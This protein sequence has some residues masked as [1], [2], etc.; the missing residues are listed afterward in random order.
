MPSAL[1][2]GE[3]HERGLDLLKPDPA[4]LLG[5]SRRFGKDGSLLQAPGLRHVAPPPVQKGVVQDREQPA[6]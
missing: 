5:W 2:V 3:A 4:F 6:A 1:L